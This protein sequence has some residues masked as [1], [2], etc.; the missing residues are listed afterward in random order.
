MYV[1][2]CLPVLEGRAVRNTA[3]PL[4]AATRVFISASLSSLHRP[5]VWCVRAREIHTRDLAKLV[6]SGRIIGSYS[7]SAL[8]ESNRRFRSL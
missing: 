7:S 6:I 4:S 2:V 1:S 8:G 3:L 5:R